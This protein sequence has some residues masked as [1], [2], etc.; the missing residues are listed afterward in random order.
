MDTTVINIKK[1]FYHAVLVKSQDINMYR[2]NTIQNNLRKAAS[3]TPRYATP[4]SNNPF[5]AYNIVTQ[6]ISESA[7]NAAAVERLKIAVSTDASGYIVATSSAIAAISAAAA[8]I[9][10]IEASRL[11]LNAN[12]SA[13]NARAVSNAINN[14]NTAYAN[15]STKQ[16][17]ILVTA[18]ESISKISSMLS[19]IN[20]VTNNSS[21]HSAVAITRRASNTILGNLNSIIEIERDSLESTEDARSV[22]TLLN[23]AYN[24]IPSITNTVQIQEK[25]WAINAAT[26]RAGEVSEKLKN[27]FF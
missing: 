26:A 2:Q 20:K 13:Q 1:C 14:L 6:E 15:T 18:L 16:P 21:A 17:I 4:T 8:A 25:L 9:S 22:L 10:P 24:I 5:S 27:S 7:A 3:S 11:A 23:T 19:T 12:I